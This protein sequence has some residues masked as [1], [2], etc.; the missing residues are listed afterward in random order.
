MLLLEVLVNVAVLPSLS[1]G[2]DALSLL[3]LFLAL[4]ILI[5]PD[6]SSFLLL[7]NILVS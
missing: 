7:L 2:H 6:A 4:Q 5:L 3:R 1:E